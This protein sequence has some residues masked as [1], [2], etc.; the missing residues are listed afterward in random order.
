MCQQTAQPEFMFCLRLQVSKVILMFISFDFITENSFFC[1]VS[2]LNRCFLSSLEL[3]QHV[4]IYISL[5]GTM[6]FDKRERE[7]PIKGGTM[8]TGGENF[9]RLFCVIRE[10]LNIYQTPANTMAL[11]GG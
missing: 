9:Q 8:R 6:S 7:K 10:N 3:V 11:N 5:L 4:K 1:F 2:D